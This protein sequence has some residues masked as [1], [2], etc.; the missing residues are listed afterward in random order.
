VAS[1]LS[2][3]EKASLIQV[4]KAL[5]ENRFGL[6]FEPIVDIRTGRPRFYE[7]LVRLL[8]EQDH[9]VAPGVFIPLAE[10]AGIMNEIDRAVITRLPGILKMR[11]H[12]EIS[13]NLSGQ[14]LTDEN[15][16]SWIL[17]EFEITGTD[18]HRII[19]EITET[20]LIE[21]LAQARALIERL[22]AAGFRFA[23]DD[24][25]AGFTSFS[26]LRELPVEML[27]ID[28]S[29]I[30]SLPEDPFSLAVVRSVNNLAHVLRLET[31]AEFVDRP[32][33]LEKLKDIGIDYA[34]GFLFEASSSDGL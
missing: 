19:F 18:P 4:R 5:V 21:N 17:E 14:S 28:G 2:A 15:L 11:P 25:G 24:F 32:E 26:Y 22:R 6:K 20:Q 29:F 27:K 10:K 16:A 12:W 33:I 9:A 34:Q 1:E 7:A 8:D 3:E 31:I 23:L 30:R 13:V